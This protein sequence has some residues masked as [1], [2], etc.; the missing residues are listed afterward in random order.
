MAEP[1]LNPCNIGP[2]G[3]NTNSQCQMYGY[4]CSDVA[5][6]IKNFAPDEAMAQCVKTH[7]STL[8]AKKDNDMQCCK[9]G[10]GFLPSSGGWSGYELKPIDSADSDP[11]IQNMLYKLFT[12]KNKPFTILGCVI[13]FLI[14]LGLIA[15]CRRR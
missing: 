10:T 14:L 5:E 7:Q 6:T 12:P 11:P 13:V 15:N 2:T 8:V 9:P 1:N 3:P 4:E